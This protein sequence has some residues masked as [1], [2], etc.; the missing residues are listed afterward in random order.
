M[1]GYSTS[2]GAGNHMKKNKTIATDRSPSF[3]ASNG[4]WL[5]LGACVVLLVVYLL[6]SPR[7]YDDDNIG[8]Y[9][10]AQAAEYNPA[11][12]V[13]SWGRPL[14]ILFFYL[15][16]KFGYWVCAWTTLVLTIGTTVLTYLAARTSNREWSWLAIPLLVFQPLF[17]MTGWS[18]CT[19][20]LAAFCL[21]LGMYFFYREQSLLAALAWSLA[22]LARTELTLILP[23][24]AIQFFLQKKYWP[25]LV[26]GTGLVLYQIAGMVI[27]GDPLFLWTTAGSFGH[28]LY[29]N[30]P[31]DHYFKRF[32][33]IVG[34]IVF[35]LMLIQL[36]T[37][38]RRLRLNIVNAS[39]VLV[40]AMHVYFYWKGN[41]ASIGFLRHFVAISPL[42]ALYAL[43]GFRTAFDNRPETEGDRR[44]WVTIAAAGAA[45]IVLSFYSFELVGHYFLS[46][47]KE[48]VKFFITA[49][50]TAIFLMH[51]YIRFRSSFFVHI[52]AL[53]VLAMSAVYFLAKEK[54]WKLA[55][56]HVAVRQFTDFYHE[57]YKGQVDKTAVVHPW[58]HFFDDSNYYLLNMSEPNPVNAH[59]VKMRSENLDTLP[60]GSIVA[61][62]SHYSWRLES[63][64]QQDSILNDSRFKLVRQFVSTDRKFGM[65]V[66]EKIK[67]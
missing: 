43:N 17:F 4:P 46:D 49:G 5:L 54:P 64:V 40:F 28:G 45:V 63:N 52:A 65:L 44:I 20:P 67:M 23:I 39:V 3:L 14:A 41:V 32:I 62:D 25:I 1:F 48:H 29:A 38:V 33:F 61:W 27:K 24:F 21:A 66:F 34:P 6:Q 18:L 8:R 2:H 19:E 16:A 56:E 35:V 42:M 10:M 47:Q 60:V 31:F 12:F 36:V 57:R 50:F 9:F 26:L 51:Q 15:P 7:P 59:Y 22:P 11:Y 30:G 13:D 37:D 53:Y 58:F 55:P